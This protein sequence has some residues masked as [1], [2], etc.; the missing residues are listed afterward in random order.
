MF[1]KNCGNPLPE[2]S[3][4]C[5]KCG[6]KQDVGKE[7]V[8]ISKGEAPQDYGKK[9]YHP[10]LVGFSNACQYPQIIQ[11]KEKVKKSNMGCLWTVSFVPVVGITIMGI[12]GLFTGDNDGEFALYMFG[13]GALLTLI[14]LLI[15]SIVKLKTR[16]DKP[17]W[18]GTVVDKSKK[19]Y[20]DRHAEKH[21]SDSGLMYYTYYSIKVRTD[22][23]KK[24]SFGQADCTELYNYFQIGD[25]VKYHPV[26]EYYEK[27][28][29]SHD[30][31]IF[32]ACCKC[33]NSIE[34][35]VCKECGMPLFK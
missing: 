2:G 8:V 32:C 12:A 23:G 18:E 24:E 26:L 21:H 17:G 5:S 10:Q 34:N 11:F 14:M 29:K 15:S 4:F 20:R 27:Y 31:Y 30:K 25:R 3:K 9:A 13:F 6:A 22:D 19:K 7:R 35:D 16:K 33:R 28:D 1:C